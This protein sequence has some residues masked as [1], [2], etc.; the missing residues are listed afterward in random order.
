MKP[1]IIIF[2][3]ISVLTFNAIYKFLPL[4]LQ[5]VSWVRIIAVLVALLILAQGVHEL[6]HDHNSKIFADITR[7]GKITKSKN[8]RWQIF[9]ETKDGETIYMI[10]DLYADV[11]Q[12]TVVTKS[13]GQKNS[14]YNAVGGVAIKFHVPETEIGDFE[15]LVKNSL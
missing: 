4:R 8:F 11:S 15:I 14:L 7:E 1:W 12:I 6:I 9:K 10:N 13:P 3:W 5:N 2:L